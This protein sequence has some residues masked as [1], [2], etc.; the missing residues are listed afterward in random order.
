MLAHPSCVAEKCRTH[1]IGGITRQMISR[2]DD[3]GKEQHTDY[4]QTQGCAG[5]AVIVRTAEIRGS[6]W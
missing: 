6:E 3:Q 4:D 5:A 1:W 2:S